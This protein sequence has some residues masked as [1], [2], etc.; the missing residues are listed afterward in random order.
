MGSPILPPVVAPWGVYTPGI[1]NNL[2]TVQALQGDAGDSTDGFDDAYNAV[3]GVLATADAAEQAWLDAEAPFEAAADVYMAITDE[4]S[5][6]L[7]AAA[8]L[9]DVLESG[10]GTAIAALAGLGAGPQ[11]ISLPPIP[12]LANIAVPQPVDLTALIASSVGAQ[13]APLIEVEQ[14]VTEEEAM[15]EDD[16]ISLEQEFLGGQ[17][18]PF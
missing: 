12:G 3:A 15:L 4:I 9:Y 5:V 13:I 14:Q 16:F 2:A 11:P 18:L 7:A 17:G 8:S 6:E 10:L 1:P